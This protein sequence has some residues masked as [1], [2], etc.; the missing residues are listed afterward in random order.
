[1]WIERIIWR[2]NRNIMLPLY[3]MKFEWVSMI[4]WI[5]E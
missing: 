4:D 5:D 1:M 3:L 2:I